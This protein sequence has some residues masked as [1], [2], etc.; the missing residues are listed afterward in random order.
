MNNILNIVIGVLLT[1]IASLLGLVL[2]PGWQFDQLPVKEL[3]AADGSVVEYPAPLDPET[4]GRGREIYRAMGCLYCHSQQVR[5]EGF[6]ADI[7]RGWGMRRSIPRDYL[8]Q[9]P[10]LLGTMRTGPDL[11]NIG[12]RQPSDEWHYLHL[13]QP[14]LTTP[15]SVMPPFR[16]L[17]ERVEQKP[18]DEAILAFEL[19][20][21]AGAAAGWILP[22]PDAIALVAYLK[23]LQQPYTVEELQ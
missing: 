10:P 3:T 19:P 20:A 16:F 9:N 18:A 22:G 6:G 4:A 11:A 13:Y 1:I 8:G 2:I 17:F 12:F 21:E 23:S 5:P 7:D 15:G 14:T